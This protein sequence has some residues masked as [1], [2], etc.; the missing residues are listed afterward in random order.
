MLVLISGCFSFEGRCW[1]LAASRS[2]F[3]TRCIL[4]EA[5]CGVSW[6][7]AGPNPPCTARFCY[8]PFRTRSPSGAFLG[9]CSEELLNTERGDPRGAAFLSR[10]RGS[11]AFPAGVFLGRLVPGRR[12]R[13]RRG[14]SSFAVTFLSRSWVP[15]S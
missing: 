4:P 1:F 5:G 14:V 11:A 8:Y 10:R 13:L 9:A 6:A 7:A 15:C 3:N 12:G 2:W